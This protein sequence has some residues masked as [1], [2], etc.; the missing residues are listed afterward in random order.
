M[1]GE[2]RDTCCQVKLGTLASH[3][4]QGIQDCTFQVSHVCPFPQL[5]VQVRIA[6][7]KE[8]I[9]KKN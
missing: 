1:V 4:L 5:T 8:N 3:M 6:S 2:I 7:F 9:I